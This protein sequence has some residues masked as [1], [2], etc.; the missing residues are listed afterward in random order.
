M[1]QGVKV[2]N[3][4]NSSSDCTKKVRHR[5]APRPQPKKTG[6]SKSS[7]TLEQINNQDDDRN[8]EQE[9][10]QTAPNMADEAKEPENYENDNDS[11]EHG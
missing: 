10:D 5:Y 6:Q 7:F 1:N 3:A 11:P 8:H 2:Q 9:M 4:A